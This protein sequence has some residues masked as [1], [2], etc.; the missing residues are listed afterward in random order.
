MKPI[1]IIILVSLVLS[2]C[3]KPRFL[4]E[5]KFSREELSVNPYSGTEELRFIDNSDNVVLFYSGNRVITQAE[6]KEN[7]SIECSD[8]YLV[9]QND[10][11]RFLNYDI[12][13][14][15]NILITNQTNP[16]T[17]ESKPPLLNFVYEDRSEDPDLTVY[18]KGLPVDS[19]DKSVIKSEFFR[20]SM[21]LRTRTIHNIFIMPG[22]RPSPMFSDGDT[23][24]FTRAEGIVALKFRD[25][26]LLTKQY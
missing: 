12:Q 17:G 10:K 23:L 22:S 13:T 18:F 3:C 24:Y 11:T 2:S 15:I 1:I 9:E 25:G 4:G 21:T 7:E 5:L 16:F 20:D 26:K 6:Y 19:I 8:Y 14:E